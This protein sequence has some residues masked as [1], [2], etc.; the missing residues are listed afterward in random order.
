MSISPLGTPYWPL[1]VFVNGQLTGAGLYRQAI[2]EVLVRVHDE[3][4]L[5]GDFSSRNVVVDHG[6][7]PFLLDFS[8]ADGGHKC[9][10]VGYCQELKDAV[11]QLCLAS[12]TKGGS[13]VILTTPRIESEVHLNGGNGLDV[14][15]NNRHEVAV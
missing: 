4:V 6:G 9:A 10:G 12:S 11:R 15:D 13:G 7:H 3:G 1:C 2:L 8:H 5:H 14:G